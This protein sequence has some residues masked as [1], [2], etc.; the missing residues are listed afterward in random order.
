M[1]K[2]RP[3]AVPSACSVVPFVKSVMQFVKQDSYIASSRNY[4]KI[5]IGDN[6]ALLRKE[7]QID[8]VAKL[9]LAGVAIS[10]YS[11]NRIE[12]DT[13][14][15]TTSLL[16]ACCDILHCDMNQLFNFK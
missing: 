16:Y 13:Q 15:P 11:Y 14:N 5:H 7:K 4:Y 2:V 10:I 1:Q 12:K 6:I 9:Q 3:Q 8:M